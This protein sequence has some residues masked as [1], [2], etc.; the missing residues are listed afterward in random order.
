MD[1]NLKK[2]R[3]GVR[4]GLFGVAAVGSAFPLL[5][6]DLDFECSPRGICENKRK[7]GIRFAPNTLTTVVTLCIKVKEQHYYRGIPVENGFGTSVEERCIN[8]TAGREQGNGH[9]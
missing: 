1:R 7:G 3:A 8:T 6:L 2:W 5:C 4:S 9:L